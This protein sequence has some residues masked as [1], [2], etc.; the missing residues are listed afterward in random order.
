MAALKT[1]LDAALG[2]LL[3]RHRGASAPDS[4]VEGQLWW[5][6]SGDPVDVLKRYTVAAGWISLLT[7]N[8]T[9]GAV[10]IQSLTLT[11]AATGFTIAGGTTSRTLT[12]DTDVTATN[13]ATGFTIAGGTTSKTLTLDTDVTAT[14]LMLKL[15]SVTKTAS[16]VLTIT[17]ISKILIMNADTDQDFTLP[18]ANAVPIGA[19]YRLKNIGAGL[20]TVVGTVDGST[21]PTLG[22]YDGM[23]VFSDGSAW[24]RSN[25]S[26]RP[27]A[28]VGDIITR[29]TS[30]V[31]E[32][33]LEC[34]G[35]SLVRATYPALFAV[36]SDDYG[37]ADG[38]HFNVP[39]YRGEFLRGWSHGVAT[40]PDRASRTA[41]ADGTGGDNVGTTQASGVLSHGHSASTT[42]ARD[43]T[44][45][46]GVYTL[47]Y[48][49]TG[50]LTGPTMPD[51]GSGGGYYGWVDDVPNNYIMST[52]IVNTGGNETRPVN[53]NVLYCI[54]Y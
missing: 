2:E 54:K 31:P 18:A 20:V 23:F 21:D 33:Y 1:F 29:P 19:W 32:G 24:Y 22:Q 26:N 25:R 38:T 36:L 35:S 6:T 4:P 40:D 7:V 11:A 50:G 13:A 42:I 48:I 34:D 5:D 51:L 53:V 52:S 39:D 44:H 49:N 9:T 27:G 41:R 43:N 46:D 10:A 3:N 37:A 8:K 16:Y 30:T 12:L 17:D 15:P 14:N 45:F 28:N 47:N